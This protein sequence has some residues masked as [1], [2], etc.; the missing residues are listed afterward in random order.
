[1]RLIELSSGWAAGLAECRGRGRWTTAHGR[2]FVAPS[3][4]T[5]G[6]LC[7]LSRV[8]TRIP[9]A[10]HAPLL[11]QGTPDF[12]KRSSHCDPRRANTNEP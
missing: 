9:S 3:Q 2:H 5:F 10:S 6:G 1:M 8:L 7:G 11:V 4:P 12:P